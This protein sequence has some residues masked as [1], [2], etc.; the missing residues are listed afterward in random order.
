M[1]DRI[2]LRR[3]LVLILMLGLAQTA[4]A[5]DSDRNTAK[6]DRVTEGG[7]LDI[8]KAIGENPGCTTCQAAAIER[9]ANTNPNESLPGLSG[10]AG[11]GTPTTK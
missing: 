7:S 5:S 10:S 11:S 6:P 2:N 8:L 9:M 3:L 1:K 4:R